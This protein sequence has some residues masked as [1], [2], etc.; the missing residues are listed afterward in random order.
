MALP[1]CTGR[2]YIRPRQRLS[3]GG[4]SPCEGKYAQAGGYQPESHD[5]PT[6]TRHEE[7]PEN[8]LLNSPEQ[9]RQSRGKQ[10]QMAGCGRNF[11]R[12]FGEI[13]P[14]HRRL[15]GSVAVDSDAA[16][17]FG[18][19][20]TD[21]IAAICADR[22]L[23]KRGGFW[24]DRPYRNPPVNG[25]CRHLPAV[26]EKGSTAISD[27]ESYRKTQGYR[28]AVGGSLRVRPPRLT[29]RPEFGQRP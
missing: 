26:P 20:Q 1:I 9:P 24:A 19:T 27:S 14:T 18:Q 8:R 7:S 6:D 5:W 22:K 15:A 17:N 11:V 25:Q 10:H 21:G 23:M 16:G 28:R 29:S 13:P 3:I 4:L 12:N 2:K